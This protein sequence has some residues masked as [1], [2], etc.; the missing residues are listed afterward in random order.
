MQTSVSIERFSFV[1][2]ACVGFPGTAVAAVKKNKNNKNLVFSR[3]LSDFGALF[4]SVL[5][6]KYSKKKFSYYVAVPVKF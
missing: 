5:L 1:A 3:Q 2:F 4:L 6:W